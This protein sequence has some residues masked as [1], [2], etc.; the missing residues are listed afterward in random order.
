[1]GN[2]D[3]SVLAGWEEDSE[4]GHKTQPM[5]VGASP[6]H[7]PLPLLT[8][9]TGFRLFSGHILASQGKRAHQLWA[10]V[11]PLGPDRAGIPLS[12]QTSQIN[13]ENEGWPK[14]RQCY[15]PWKSRSEG[16]GEKSGGLHSCRPCALDTHL[17]YLPKF[18][19]HH[20]SEK[21]VRI[22]ARLDVRI[23]RP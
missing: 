20:S 12:L 2:S 22:A 14:V 1:M 21:P 13:T 5:C 10:I 8:K 23:P 19:S 9:L 18:N 15:E 3:A 6:I 4:W 7:P 17:N 11:M 16:C